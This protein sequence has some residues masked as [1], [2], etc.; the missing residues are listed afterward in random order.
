MLGVP[1]V[2]PEDDFFGLGGHSLLATRLVSRVRGVFGVEVPVRAVFEAPSVAGLVRWVE[3]GAVSGRAG[4]AVRERPGTIPLSYAQR[5]LWALGKLADTGALYH[6]C[7]AARLHGALDRDAL[8]AAL[9]DVVARHESLRTLYP[10]VDGVPHQVIL[11]PDAARPRLGVL[12][13][14]PED[15]DRAV[16]AV[17]AEPFALA[18]EPPLRARLLV[19]GPESHLLVLVLHHIAGDAGSVRPLVRDLSAAYAARRTGEAPRWQP[20]PVQYADYTLWQ[21]ET[22]GDDSDPDS[23]LCRQLAYWRQK[24]TGLPE[25]L[26]LP[27]DRP[28]PAE[29]RHEG[30]VVP[31]EVDPELHQK[32]LD[33]AR[34][35]GATP[36]M[37]L[38][39]ALGALL[40][41]LG[42][43]TDLPIGAAVS[44]RGDESL[45]DLVGFFVNTLVLRTDTSGDPAFRELLARVRESD[46][47]A[48]AHQDV[49]FDRLVEELN[50]ARSLARHPLFQVMLVLDNF[51]RPETGLDGLRGTDPADDT[52]GD[53]AVAV[54][55]P[56][57][58]PGRAKFD[59]SV[60]LVEQTGDGEAAGLAGSVAYAR[61]LFDRSTVA[62]ITERFV[63][64]LRAVVTDPGRPIGEADI[65]DEAE[66]D[67]LLH[68]WNAT[69]RPLPALLLP[70]LFEEQ[71]AR[72]P[73]AP[74]VIR[75]ADT[76]SYAELDAR[77]NRVAR[78][79]VERGAGPE[80][81]VALMVPRSVEMIVAVLAAL[82]SGAAYLPVDSEYPA[83]RIAY[84]LDDARPVLAVTTAAA[85]DRLPS[86]VD[87]IVL[88][89]PA[90]VDELSRRSAADLTD[91]DRRAP[92]TPRTPAYVI[93][94]SG[95]TGRPKGVVVEHRSVP[96]IVLAR[97]GAYGMG[98]GSRAL[99]F[100]SLSFDA[101]VSEI[102][103][104]LCAGACLVLGPADMLAQAD[105]LPTLIRRHGVTHATLPPA[106]LAQLPA[107][108]LPSVVNLVIAGEAAQ[109]S[110]V[111]KWA[112]GRRM[113]NAYGPTETTVSCTMAGP[114]P[115]VPGV[116]PIGGPLPNARVYVLDDAL[117]PVPVGVPG[118]LY[119]SGLGVA[120]GY[121]GRAALT[122]E[123]FVADPYGPAGSRMY[124]TG[125][126][127][128]R[129][130]DGQLEFA[131]RADDQVKIRGFRIELGEVQSALTSCPGVG[132][133]VAVVREG[134][135][136]RRRLVGYVTPVPG[137]H[138]DT[139]TDVDPELIRAHLAGLL[140]EHM[141]PT[142]V[143]VLDRIPL[144]VNGKV[145]HAALP[146]PLPPPRPATADT[147]RRPADSREE[148]LCQVV[149]DVLAVPRI[150]VDE[151]FFALGGDSIT[152]LQ[153]A[154]RARAA[155]LVVTP[156]DLFRHQ[157]V[158]EL[159]AA[160][161]ESA[162]QDDRRRDDGIGAVPATPVMRWL[163]Q[164][165][166]PVA[167][168]NQSVLLTVP[169]LGLEALT[170][171]VQSLIDHHDALRATLVGG[172]TKVTWGLK[173]APRG[174]LPARER[175]RRVDITAHPDGSPELAALVAREGEAARDRLDPESGSMF[176]V[177]WFDA[178]PGRPGRLLLIA[179][180]LVVDGVSWR[181]LVPDLAQAW[182]T[183]AAGGE[184]RLAPVG[185]SLRR[186]AQ[187]LLAEGQDPERA[188]EL[189]LWTGML[190]GDD[191]RIGAGALTPARDT[192]GTAEYLSATLPAD[193]T[194]TLLTSVAE[195][196]QVR[197]NDI[198]LTGLALAV[199]DWRRRHG[200]D[201][202]RADHTDRT[203]LLD[204]E[205]HGREEIADEIDLSRTVGWF[206]SVFP[207]RLDPGEP[208][209]GEPDPGRSSAGETAVVDALKR[210][211]NRLRELPD[212][213]LGFGLLRYLNP[214][215]AGV[216]APYGSPQIG[217][218]YLGRMNGAALD[219][220]LDGES[221]APTEW[222]VSTDLSAGVD[223]SDGDL[224]FAHALE[225][226]AAVRE[227]ADG[228][229]L[230][231]SC[232]WPTALFPA[233]EV[234]DLLD[235]WLRALR[236]LAD[237]AGQSGACGLVPADLPLVSV[238]QEEIDAWEAGPDGV[239]DV[240]PLSPL[241]E[242]LFFHALFAGTG[243]DVYTMQT[244]LD[245]T[246]PL[247]ATA[248]RA[249]G[250]GVLDRHPNLRAG[251]H[252]RGGGDSV[253][254]IPRRAELPWAEVDLSGLDEPARQAEL[255]RLTDDA[256]TRRFHLGRPPL[257]RFT[258]IKLGEDRHRL[259]ILKHHILLDGWSVPLFMRD[260]FA[261]YR[262]GDQ[263]TLPPVVPYRGYLDWLS[264]QDRAATE[265]AW[266]EAL[267][268]V[269]EPTLLAGA[270][271][272][273]PTEMPR[274]VTR[275][276]PAPLTTALQ[277]QAARSA[278]T[279]NTFLQGAWAVLAG[280]LLGRDD[281]V[282]GTTVSGRPPE[283]PGIESM[284]GLFI[285]TIPVRVRLR[286]GETWQE[287][288]ARVQH[289][290]TAL[291]AHHQLGLARIQQLA[292][293][294]EL[295]D[296]LVVYENFPAA[297]SGQ[298]T[299]T[300]LTAKAKE[301]RAAAHYP[302]AL[303]AN[304]TPTGLRLRLEYR[305]EL[306]TA[307]RAQELLD[308]L[309]RVLEQVIGDPRQPV[310]RIDVLDPAERR[311]LLDGW[312][313]DAFT[314]AAAQPA[315][316]HGRFADAVAQGPDH[317]AIRHR[318]QHLT[319]RELD[320]R[321]NRLARLLGE[322]GVGRETRVAVLLDRGVD[323]VVAVLA[324]LKAGA[325]YVPLET[326]TPERRQ[327]LLVSETTA[328]VLLT[329]EHLT[330]AWT[331]S[332][333]AGVRVVAVD[334]DPRLP[335]QDVTA[336]HVEVAPDQLAYVIYTSGS[337]GTPKGVAVTHQNVVELAA[338]RW[339]DLDSR[340][341]VLFHSPH[342]WDASTLE[343]WVPL[344]DHG[345]IVVAPPGKLDL[346]ALASLVVEE[347]V[348]GLWAS[349]GLFRLLAEEHP[350]C[351]A[352]LS[353]VRTGGDV[354][355]ADAVR[356]ALR[357]CPDTVVTAGY[358]PTETTVFSTRHSMR[359]GD[360]V[361]ESVPIGRPLDGTRAYVLSPGLEPVP[362]G[363]VGEL[364]LAGSG[365]SR[366]YE[367][368]PA[369]TAERFVADLY[370]PPGT[371]MY[372]TGDLVRR[373]ADGLMEFAGRAD[374][375]V[376]LR[377]FRVELR[378]VEMAVTGHPGIGQAVALVREDRPG[379][380]RLVAYVVPDAGSPAPDL[381]ALRER[382]ACVL[383]E[384]M[385]PSAFVVLDRLPLTDNTKLDR[386]ALPAPDH[387]AE[388]T[389]PP[390]T[391]QEEVL[392]A[393]F[394]DALGVPEV[395]LDDDFF[396]L[397]GN[398]LTAAALV[399]RIRATLG[400][401]LSVQALFTAPTV[402]ALA[403]RLE[404]DT[405]PDE[406][407]G[408]EV[409]LPLR[410]TGEQAPVFCFHA[411]GGLSWRYAGLLRHLPP[412]HP[413]YGLQARAYS[414][415]GYRPTGIEE[416]AADFVE[417]IR[418]VRPTGPYHLLGWSF[419]GLVAHAVAARLQDDGDEVATLALL[420]AYPVET[421]TEPP[422]AAGDGGELLR[423]LLEVTHAAP[424]SPGTEPVTREE[425]AEALRALGNPLMELLADRLD[426]VL[427]AFED[428]VDLRHAFVPRTFRG[429]ALLFAALPDGA[430][431]LS[432]AERWQPYVE[433]RVHAHTVRCAH[434]HMMDPEPLAE[435][436]RIVTAR[437]RRTE[438]GTDR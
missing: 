70:Q 218:N 129:R 433:G 247:D 33:L 24:L 102:C 292:G 62:A 81:V 365:V 325:V 341:K 400:S 87:R 11:D 219:A 201:T 35:H 254:I 220:A 109:A 370:G 396:M 138:T 170:T 417:Q 161:R 402:A 347:R 207:L 150:G 381:A 25:E 5:R 418:K 285:N 422:T 376:K 78:L 1:V 168:L 350:E 407:G 217:F 82:K 426:T 141:V 54:E 301:G 395:G 27:A 100:A 156:R 366:G 399:S 89:D 335:G 346:D 34:A 298:S 228:P 114:L 405:G 167:H 95:S 15:A 21:R 359:A 421:D 380:K 130:A 363:V 7:L 76:V 262:H 84:M 409:L 241:Q 206:T 94:T 312:N 30:G 45:D 48:Y 231:V 147:A 171:A 322:L 28:R 238:T 139:V 393:L 302:L 336:P 382:L 259:L 99:Q 16:D 83:D 364:Y 338:D 250:Q 360:P 244:T 210:I 63:R 293:V 18:A 149:A 59:L 389:R 356:R 265:A 37:V 155:G 239:Q 2:G 39:A 235:T 425:A 315:T 326:D 349:G 387:R 120:R 53:A 133:A 197:M 164:R 300:A 49:P 172:A 190:D 104:P 60:R 8:E 176:Q 374:E 391:P 125:D 256:R 342:A 208:D 308:R 32:L 181:I 255:T 295:F 61:D 14:R 230:S 289:E 193:L 107:D 160:V 121:L 173:V 361:P 434:E 90:T 163:A 123:R 166:G 311:Q 29:A 145:D 274:N 257:I 98:P 272:G 423:A 288:T 19:L 303:I 371:R 438:K 378:E 226:T 85:A 386:G 55:P 309:V 429:D 268:G 369:M 77:A 328:P 368:N 394:A 253:Q 178:G 6:I 44:G 96:N 273:P 398:S 278:T 188:A 183:T 234:Q 52:G 299:D 151:N 416:I 329:H 209:L 165:R 75:G 403:R 304:M 142:A 290:Q 339:W 38:H 200:W 9:A 212:N 319:Y 51:T 189:D 73:D 103:T 93:Y 225:L 435:I 258:L 404:P 216:L 195:T 362:V 74:A 119:V 118:E 248:L 144:T 352:G 245:L 340:R 40:T 401:A 430:D 406:N 110:L 58:A 261:L 397:G 355:P 437:L 137:A 224:P 187:L 270:E 116:P 79:L 327:R 159:A 410:T 279:V 175:V 203:V 379:D 213:G 204:V 46:L 260:L 69:E 264:R 375:Q 214:D 23:E 320:E 169:A 154:S 140:P 153:V 152:A 223:P 275:D 242:G 307:E 280:R 276:L 132:R 383:P 215:T 198:L 47:A 115:A 420:D 162:P 233:E 22:L 174:D 184:P 306:L 205:G 64:L 271:P 297:T 127:A 86:A 13:V 158:A 385:V 353:E 65:L 314:R 157:T 324:V 88:D 333:D 221:P 281:I 243:P 199:A 296:A 122:A 427:E 377:G 31:F 424:S 351:F 266:S 66:R 105:Q 42:A 50:P 284:L 20:L 186:F 101:A 392:C 282:F 313:G 177:V 344:L 287:L 323:L 222:S 373:R 411:G 124:R 236:S 348:T 180:H 71:A 331:A 431:A 17:R 80:S 413:V 412:E 211:K 367:N 128:R 337:T 91:A 286:L 232:A 202:D 229:R 283:I 136:G 334:A 26:A 143:M 72:T 135:P 131:G 10:E 249:A 148:L 112:A 117:R 97:I 291:S 182:R 343:W 246:G 68:G 227:M 428:H 111:P 113:F 92:L 316:I 126:L 251:F 415:P 237:R 57:E 269:S 56:P 192:R 414:T 196:F 12:E 332:P 354:V 185:T 43:G 321:A 345:E 41:R 357:A 194:G 384:F 106:I 134:R 390:R 419:G 108:S 372:R 277:E 3:S 436:G 318:D 388:H 310:A 240:L 252:H 146:A 179:H 267:A 36:F 263:N 305:P 358:G 4:L 330:P 294:G 408:L 432:R 317:T 191:P 67:R